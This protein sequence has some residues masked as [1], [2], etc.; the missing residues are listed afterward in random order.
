MVQKP[1]YTVLYKRF[2]TC[3]CVAVFEGSVY[4]NQLL[5]TVIV[6]INYHRPLPANLDQFHTFV[7]FDHRIADRPTRAAKL[8]G[9]ADMP[10]SIQSEVDIYFFF[11][12]DN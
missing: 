12:S 7:A 2:C 6:L 1:Q 10:L 3:H 5:R 4:K 9:A 8:Q 11:E